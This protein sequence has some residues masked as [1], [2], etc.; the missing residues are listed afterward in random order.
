MCC[1]ECTVSNGREHRPSYGEAQ[2]SVVHVVIV[3]R[4]REGGGVKGGGV[5]GG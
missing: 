5:R 2:G 3:G 4:L 1:S